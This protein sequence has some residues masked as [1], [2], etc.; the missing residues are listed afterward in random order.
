MR[1]A[2][3]S[4]E[5]PT[6]VGHIKMFYGRTNSFLKEMPDGLSIVRAVGSIIQLDS[7]FLLSVHDALIDNSIQFVVYSSSR[8]RSCFRQRSI[9]HLRLA[10]ARFCRHVADGPLAVEWCWRTTQLN[11]SHIA[12]RPVLSLSTRGRDIGSGTLTNREASAIARRG[13]IHLQTYYRLPLRRH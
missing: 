8:G 3:S 6:L 2:R 1:M 13:R 4:N 10:V 5:K 7:A 9:A 12:T 11:W